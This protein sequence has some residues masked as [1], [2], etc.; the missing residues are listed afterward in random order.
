MHQIRFPE[1]VRSSV[2]L[3]LR[4]RLT[5]IVSV[6]TE[7]EPA[8]AVWLLRTAAKDLRLVLFVDVLHLRQVVIRIQNLNS[9]YSQLVTG[10]SRKS[11][12]DL[13]YFI[14]NCFI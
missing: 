10:K 9:E 14:L 2:R 13:F 6:L 7:R 1:S 11:D 8:K 3:C 4:W 5:P 12:Y